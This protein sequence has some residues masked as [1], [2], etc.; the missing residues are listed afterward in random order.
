MLLSIKPFLQPFCLISPL[1]LSAVLWISKD[2]P[3][4]SKTCQCNLLLYLLVQHPWD[5][6]GARWRTAFPAEFSLVWLCLR[7]QKCILL[8][9]A[10]V[11]TLDPNWR[12]FCFYPLQIGH[13]MHS[14]H[15]SMAWWYRS[16]MR[17][18]DARRTSVGVKLLRLKH[19]QIQAQ[20]HQ[21][22]LPQFHTE[23]TDCLLLINWS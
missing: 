9:L 19:C 18:C 16:A 3:F 5:H 4:L 23:N 8:M 14:W 15:S 10:S 11:Y 22:P 21:S 17:F 1:E 7:P 20:S 2:R 13:Q 6:C 12:H